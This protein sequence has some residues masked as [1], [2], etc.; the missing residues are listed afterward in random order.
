MTRHRLV[1][2]ERAKELLIVDWTSPCGLRW[3]ESGQPAGTLH[4]A[5]YRKV[6][7]DGQGYLVHR[8]VWALVMGCDPGDCQVDHIDGDRLNNNPRNL[9]LV[10]RSS[11]GVNALSHR[12]SRSRFR[13]V[14]YNKRLGKWLSQVSKDKVRHHAGYHGCETSAALARD[15]K[16]LEVQGPTAS[17]N[18]PLLSSRRSAIS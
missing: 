10:D 4:G 12:D 14:S 13:G 15:R 9:R 3:A 8:I 16:A 1:P 2:L 17:L 18:F 11:N 7:L 6:S 5:G